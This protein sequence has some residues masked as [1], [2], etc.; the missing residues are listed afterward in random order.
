MSDLLNSLLG[1][2]INMVGGG[3]FHLVPNRNQLNSSRSY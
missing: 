1:N 3:L 2:E